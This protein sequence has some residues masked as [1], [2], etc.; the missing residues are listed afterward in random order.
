ML[1]TDKP[2]EE[3]IHDQPAIKL[4]HFTRDEVDAVLT[5]IKSRKAAGLD[6]I[7]TEVWKI[8]WHTRCIQ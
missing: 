1:L 7:P 2:T 3:I 5:V 4:G 8:E 6:E